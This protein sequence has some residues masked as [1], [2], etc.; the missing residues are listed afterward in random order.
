MLR[1]TLSHLG[2]LHIPDPVVESQ[3]HRETW[4]DLTHIVHYQPYPTYMTKSEEVG[5]PSEGKL[6]GH[7]MK[8]LDAGGADE[9]L[10]QAFGPV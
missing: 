10:L 9:S 5:S 3:G 6:S 8:N 1:F 4:V 7:L 2:L